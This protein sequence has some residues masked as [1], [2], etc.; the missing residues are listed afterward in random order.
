MTEKIRLRYAPSPTGYLH[1]GNTRTALMNYLFAKHFNGDFIVRIEDTDLER[2]VEGAIESQFANLEWLGIDIDESFFK[3]GNES[4]GK[5]KQSEKFKR[6]EDFANKLVTQKKAYFCFCTLEELEQDYKQQEA[7]GIV[8]TKYS[9]KCK[10]LLQEEIDKKISNNQ[11][12]S[13]RFAVIDDQI[14]FEDFVKG[15]ISF[16]SSQLGDFVILKSNKIATYNFAVVVDDHDMDITHVLRGE[17]HISNTPRQILIYKAFDWKMPV[18][19]HMSLIIDSSGKKL[20]KRSGNA[21]FFIEQYKKQGY[22]PEAMLNYISLLGWSP[23][24]E[25]EIFSKDELIKI[26][27]DKRFSKSPSTFDMTKM[28]WINSQYMKKMSDEKYLDFVFNFINKEIYG[29][30]SKSKDWTNKMLLLFKNEIEFGEQI[31]DHLDLFFVDKQI[32]LELKS[33]FNEI[34]NAPLVLNAFEQGLVNIKEWTIEEIKELIKVVSNITQ[35]KGKELFMS[36][37]IGCT[38]SEHGPSLADVIYLLGKEK[39]L[40]NIKKVK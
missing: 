19:G 4:Y 39:V 38:A 8:A 29:I 13:I 35:T 11:E 15:N 28:K 22:L 1:I 36:A 37:R 5:Y 17:E 12:Y 34:L 18:F 31:N 16:D 30:E 40:D 33:K 26:F 10:L 3:P 6:Y 24:G 21:L 20:S 32:S 25:K 2:N 14:H 9:G 27:D 23:S 7:K